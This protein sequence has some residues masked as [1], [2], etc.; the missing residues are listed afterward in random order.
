MKILLAYI[1]GETNRDDPYI[2][3]VP[4]GLC[5]LHAMLRTAGFDAVL[6]NFSGWS[7]DAIGR[8]IE[9][10]RPALAGISQWTHNRHASLR[11][12]RLL[13]QALPECVIL[14]GGAHATFRHEVLLEREP[15]VDA[16]IL[17]EGETTLLELVRRMAAGQAWRDLDGLALRQGGRVVVQKPPPALTDLDRLPFSASFLEK[18]SVGIDLE[19]QGEFIITA[20][21]CPSACAFCSSPSFWARKLR[22]RSPENVVEEILFLRDTLGLIYFSIR[23]DTFTADRRRAIEICRLLIERKAHVVWNCQSRVSAI[24]EGLLVWMKR[25]GCECVQV[26]VESGSPRILKQLGKSITP[27][28]VENAARLVREAG[29][30]LSVYLISDVPG[31]T[32]ED[33]ALTI[34]L[35]RRIRPDDGYVSPLAYFP[36]TR[37]YEEAASAGHVP[38]DLFE[39]SQDTALYA[40]PRRGDAARRL[41]KSMGGA[42][43]GPRLFR[44]VKARIGYCHVSCVV[45]GEW[46]RQRGDMPAAE[47]EFREI[48]EREPDNPWGWFLLGELYGENGERELARA[49]YRKVL[50]VVPLHGPSLRA[51]EQKKKRG[52]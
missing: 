31:E 14:L 42:V 4:T 41:L 48:V 27:A 1:S 11:L 15:A 13:R 23:D 36:G 52:R 35:M 7:D 17:G 46:Y 30:H 24:D 28:Q 43:A 37:L 21:G 16:V 3:L 12:A 10:L 38:S 49:C 22:F 51:V 2:S 45:A 26:G 39:A 34:D 19:L 8:E 47:R 50:A 5:Q 29:I 18:Y 25:A 44:Q 33:T 6:A 9:R 32:D 40:V 20:R